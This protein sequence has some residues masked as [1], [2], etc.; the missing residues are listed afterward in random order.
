MSG[1]FGELFQ[2]G[3]VVPVDVAVAAWRRGVDIGRSSGLSVLEWRYRE[4]VARYPST[5]PSPERS[6]QIELIGRAIRRLHVPRISRCESQG[7]QHY[8]FRRGLRQALEP[9]APAG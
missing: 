1:L 6:V 4:A 3:H 9:G 2:L 5:W 8:G 7:L